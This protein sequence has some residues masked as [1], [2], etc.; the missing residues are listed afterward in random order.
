MPRKNPIAQLRPQG[1]R[2][3]AWRDPHRN[4]WVIEAFLKVSGGVK[5]AVWRQTEQPEAHE[6]R[7]VLAGHPMTSPRPYVLGQACDGSITSCVVALFA[8]WCARTGRDP[9][10]LMKRAYPDETD[11]STASFAE[12]RERA[13]WE[14]VS[15]PEA[16]GL[17]EQNGLIS[18]LTAIN[19]HALCSEVL[20]ELDRTYPYE[21]APETP[22]IGFAYA[23]RVLGDDWRGMFMDS[24]YR[25][26]D[27]AMARLARGFAADSERHAKP[28]LRKAG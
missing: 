6:I 15:Y 5:Y 28:D 18:S 1:L 25:S 4:E 8:E 24:M 9:V 23:V 16:W 7:S 14:G 10:A 26:T 17:L 2:W 27:T 19:Y 21:T 3:D 13:E 20:D 22:R 12:S 11:W